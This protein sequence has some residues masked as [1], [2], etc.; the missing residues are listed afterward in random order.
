MPLLRQIKALRVRTRRGKSLLLKEKQ[1]QSGRVPVESQRQ[2]DPKGQP[3]KKKCY[4]RHDVRQHIR[5]PFLAQGT[6]PNVLARLPVS[7]KN[8]TRARRAAYRVSWEGGD[9]PE[10]NNF[11]SYRNPGCFGSWEGTVKDIPSSFTSMQMTPGMRIL[12]AVIVEASV[13]SRA[14]VRCS[15]V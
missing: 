13:R 9:T 1:A 10:G 3:Q 12:A 4:L 7:H 2:K 14:L 15:S 6:S 8:C 11:T 5:R